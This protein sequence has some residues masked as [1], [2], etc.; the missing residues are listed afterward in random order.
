MIY[1]RYLPEGSRIILSSMEVSEVELLH[2]NSSV[3]DS[4][5]IHREYR[6]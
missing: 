2:R 1:K 5:C 3:H 4:T 6:Y